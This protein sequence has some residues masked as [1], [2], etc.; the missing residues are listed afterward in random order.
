MNEQIDS[1]IARRLSGECSPTEEAELNAWIAAKPEHAE[2]FREMESA[3]H[4]MDDVIGGPQ[5]NTAAAWEQ[6][7]PRLKPVSAEPANSKPH[8][9][10]IQLSNWVKYATAAAAV[11]IIAL[12]FLQPEAREIRVVAVNGDEFVHL[13]DKSTIRLRKG[14]TLRYPEHFSATARLVHL[15]GEAFFDVSKREE[16]RFVVDAGS[17]SV[18]VLGT[19]FNVKSGRYA[20]DVSVA[21]GR[22]QLV[23]KEPAGKKILLGAGRAAHF[24][25]GFFIETKA[26]AADTAWMAK[27]VSYANTPLRQI[28]TELAASADTTIGIDSVIEPAL[29][30]GE[31]SI[32]FGADMALQ[33]RLQKLGR[34]TGTEAIRQGS[35]YLIRMRRP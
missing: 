32:E 11:L 18:N 4:A 25:N 29:L 1:L 22:V 24:G 31:V 19:S 5:F 28:I 17:V 7:A 23:A 34:I 3:W 6:V 15:D 13:P 20:A 21:T 33:E 16:Q 26:R 30:N 35:G 2:Y 27:S 10:T 14:S 9:K 8:G 12:L